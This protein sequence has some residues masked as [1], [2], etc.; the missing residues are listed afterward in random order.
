MST[1]FAPSFAPVTLVL[2]IST[3]F[4]FWSLWCV[5][6]VGSLVVTAPYATLAVWQVM[7]A[8]R[9]KKRGCLLR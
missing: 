6:G 4:H 2:I 3:G 1:S 5:L 7:K 8:G 9:E